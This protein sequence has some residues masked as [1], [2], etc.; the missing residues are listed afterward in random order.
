M[1]SHKHKCIFV[2]IPKCG[3]TSLEN[4]IWPMPRKESDLWMGFISAY[5][6]RYQTGGLQ[7]LFATHIL[8]EV[9][10]DIFEA[11][12]K[13]TI[14]RN[15]W[16][17][18]VSQYFYMK[19]R[20]D[21]REFIG[22]KENDSFKTYLEL[23]RKKIHVQ[24]EPQYKFF[25]DERGDNLVNFTGRLE[26][27]VTDAQIIFSRLGVTAAVSQS[28]ATRHEHYSH[29]YDEESKEIVAEMYGEDIRM[30]KYSFQRAE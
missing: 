23:I 5:H 13:F 18:A 10:K 2:H 9:G 3:G 11:Y 25:T 8:Q 28:N 4:V 19:K 12:F 26:N 27:I 20:N 7:H 16:D 22:M 17:K 6:N 14:V 21:L 29:Y 24:W 15:P 1:I 30:L